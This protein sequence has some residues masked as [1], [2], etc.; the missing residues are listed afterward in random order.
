MI[1]SCNMNLEQL[2]VWPVQKNMLKNGVKYFKIPIYGAP[3]TTYGYQL[4]I[5]GCSRMEPNTSIVSNCNKSLKQLL[6][7]SVDRYILKNG[8]KYLKISIYGPTFTTYWYQLYIYSCMR[9]ECNI[10]MNSSCNM[11]LKQLLV[12]P[13]VKYMLKNGVKYFKIPIYGAPFTTKRY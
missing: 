12:W 1:S 13:V 5:F 9:M 7:Q 3:F 8:V 6:V 11:Y 4:Q 2:L 10:S